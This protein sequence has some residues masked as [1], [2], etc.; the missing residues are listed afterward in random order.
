MKNL[1][2]IVFAYYVAVWALV[3]TLM[4]YVTRRMQLNSIQV[5]Y[6]LSLYGF[7][8]MFSES[9]MVRLIVPRLGETNSMRLGLL[10]FCVQCMIIAFARSMEELYA[11]IVFSMFSN[12]VYP[13][14]SSLVS[15]LV[16]EH[17]QGEALGTLNGI[18][19]LTEGF[20]P[21]I[22]GMLMSLYEHFPSIPA[23]PYILAAYVAFWAFLHCYELPTMEPPGQGKTQSLVFFH[24]F[25]RLL[26]LSS[27]HGS[28]VSADEAAHGMY[29]LGEMQ[30]HGRDGGET[31]RSRTI[32]EILHGEDESH[33]E[34]KPLLDENTV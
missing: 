16:E 10:A 19:A 31:P 27:D 17:L 3:S 20:G 26:G 6:L 7:A 34:T 21:L 24:A 4:V 9:V 29:S 32:H 12:L 14:I 28:A 23:A 30:D 2:M 18:K 25:N 1:G 11:S 13:S 22:F 15:R 5:G 8:T 33:C